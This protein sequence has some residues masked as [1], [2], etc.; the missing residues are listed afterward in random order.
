MGNK[1]NPSIT[2]ECA[3][4]TGRRRGAVSDA[5]VTWVITDTA[6][7]YYRS[8]GK[9]PDCVKAITGPDSNPLRILGSLLLSAKLALN[10]NFDAVRQPQEI[11]LLSALYH[12]V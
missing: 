7:A 3:S 1:G 6:Y 8:Y 5:A 10:Q 11:T 9:L 12:L 4:Y 2:D